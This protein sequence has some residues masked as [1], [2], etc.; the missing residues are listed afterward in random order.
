MQ[1]AVQVHGALRGAAGAAFDLEAMEAIKLWVVVSTGVLVALLLV[2]ARSRGGAAERSMRRLVFGPIAPAFYG[3][4]V[5]L[6]IVIPIALGA[7]HAF[8]AGGLAVLAGI[9]VA[10]LVGDFYVK[11]C[12]V[13]AGVYVP[14]VGALGPAR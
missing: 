12:V 11:Y 10:S 1:V 6:G 9:G 13:K 2:S 4:T 5:L 8:G 3:G 7:A 14:T